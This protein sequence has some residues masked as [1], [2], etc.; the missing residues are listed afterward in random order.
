VST[1]L[2]QNNIV[3][4][5]SKFYLCSNYFKA[6]AHK[7]PFNPSSS[8]ATTPLQLVHTYLW[9]SSPILSNSGNRYYVAFIDEYSRF[10]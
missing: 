9:G 4:T 1:I 10:T 8:V 6:K 3:V 5:S 7:L 2:A